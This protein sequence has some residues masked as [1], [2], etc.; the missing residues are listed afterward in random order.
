M[1]HSAFAFATPD[2]IAQMHMRVRPE[3]RRMAERDFLSQLGNTPVVTQSMPA[4][5]LER[6][7]QA[8]LRP[9]SQEESS[10]PSDS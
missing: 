4:G 2:T 8:I 9:P 7:G 6:E 1:V 3:R 10:S 5:G